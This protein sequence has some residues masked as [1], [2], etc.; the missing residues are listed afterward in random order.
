MVILLLYGL[1]LAVAADLLYMFPYEGSVVT[2][3]SDAHYQNV[4]GFGTDTTALAIHYAKWFSINIVL[5][6][7]FT[8]LVISIPDGDSRLRIHSIGHQVLLLFTRPV[9]RRPPASATTQP[10]KAWIVTLSLYITMAGILAGSLAYDWRWIR[11]YTAIEYFT[12]S[13]C[14]ESSAFVVCIPSESQPAGS[15]TNAGSTAIHF[16]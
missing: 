3:V 7:A 11:V 6:G 2:T 13:N 12:S 15:K 14:S 1:S 10:E 16:V 5:L 8:F 4:L 9:G